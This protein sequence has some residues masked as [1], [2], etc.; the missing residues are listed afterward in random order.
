MK[1]MYFLTGM[2]LFGID[3]AYEINYTRL[4]YKGWSPKLVR[5]SSEVHTYLSPP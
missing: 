3:T 1:N 4:G 5:V 2:P